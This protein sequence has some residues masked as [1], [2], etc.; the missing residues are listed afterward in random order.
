MKNCEN[1]GMKSGV[2]KHVACVG[3]G[4]KKKER[5]KNGGGILWQIFRGN[6]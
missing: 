1:Y 6:K 2:G 4:D 5:K 3:V